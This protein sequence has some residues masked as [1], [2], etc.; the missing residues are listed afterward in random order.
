MAEIKSSI[1]RP[2]WADPI[3][4]LFKPDQINQKNNIFFSFTY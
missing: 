1:C 3:K 4:L 2:C